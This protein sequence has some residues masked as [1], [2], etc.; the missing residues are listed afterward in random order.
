MTMTIIIDIPRVIPSVYPRYV[1][2]A[3]IVSV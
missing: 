2:R 1:C 3:A